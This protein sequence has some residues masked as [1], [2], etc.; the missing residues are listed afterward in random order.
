[1]ADSA[2]Y[3]ATIYALAL[4]DT[5]VFIGGTTTNK[6]RKLLKSDLSFVADSATAGA[7][8]YSLALNDTHIFAGGGSPA[9]IRKYL[10]SDLS[11]VDTSSSTVG[12]PSVI[13]IDDSYIYASCGTVNQLRVYNISDLEF[14][15]G[16]PAGTNLRGLGLDDLN[17]YISID[18]NGDILKLLKSDLSFVA[19]FPPY[20][21]PVHQ[22]IVD[23]NDVFAC[24]TTVEQVNKY[25]KKTL[26]FSS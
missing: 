10:I 16:G 18:T 9:A 24:G 17:V 2:T 8:I 20:G 15:Q 19:S 22:I 11:L 6:V 23:G 5:H 7:T 21:G 1:V 13:K 12:G 25:Q 26:R 14:V 3:G 4:N